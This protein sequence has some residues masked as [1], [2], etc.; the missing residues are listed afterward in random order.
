MSKIH[1]PQ[2]FAEATPCLFKF[3]HDAPTGSE[4]KFNEHLIPPRKLIEATSPGSPPPE[5]AR[6]VCFGKEFR[7]DDFPEIVGIPGTGGPFD[8]SVP[9]RSSVYTAPSLIRRLGLNKDLFPV[10]EILARKIKGHVI[11][12]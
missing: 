1:T 3:T 8:P 10:S 5:L 11:P 7:D 2:E 9:V 4:R 12:I 6:E